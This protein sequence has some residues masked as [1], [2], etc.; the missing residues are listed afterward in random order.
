[1]KWVLAVILTNF[2]PN[3]PIPISCEIRRARVLTWGPPIILGP[4]LTWTKHNPATN[5][6]QDP[7][8]P[9]KNHLFQFLFSPQLR[10]FP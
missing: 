5:L 9:M 1:M 6:P 4:T 8:Y 3:I 10:N 2:Y 7:Y